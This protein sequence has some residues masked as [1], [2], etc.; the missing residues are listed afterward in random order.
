MG[1]GAFI[2]LKSGRAGPESAKQVEIRLANLLKILAIARRRAQNG[3]RGPRTTRTGCIGKFPP[4][5]PNACGISR[6]VSWITIFAGKLT[7]YPAEKCRGRLM[8]VSD[9]HYI[10]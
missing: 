8:Q 9:S 2:L 5:M 3:W 6:F 10:Q 4:D 7:Q 1:G